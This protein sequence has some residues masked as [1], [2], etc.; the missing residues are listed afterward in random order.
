[1]ATELNL[2][3]AIAYAV[4]LHRQ[5]RLDPAEALYRR[6]LEV[7]PEH[8]DVLHFLGV[9]TN[10]KGR[11]D[12]AIALIEQAI[13][14]V[15]DFPDFHN[16]LGNILALAGRLDEAERHYRRVLELRLESPDTLSNLATLCRAQDRVGEAEALLNTALS[17]APDHLKSLNNFGL[18]CDQLERH[19]DAIGYYSRAISLMPQHADGHHLLGALYFTQ[20]RLQEA[21][22]VYRHWMEVTPDHPTPRHMYAACSGIDVPVRAADDYVERTFDLFAESFEQQLQQK[23]SYR[24]PELVAEASARVLPAPCHALDV[25]DAGCGTG[26][27]GPL[28]KPWA[29]RMV[30]VDLSSGMLQKATGKACYDELIKAELTSWIAAHPVQFDLIV[31]AD[32]LCYF[33]SLAEP[34]QAAARALR[35]GGVLTF[36][37]EATDESIADEGHKINPHGRYSHTIGHIEAC[38][39]ASGFERC[40]IDSAI[41]RTENGKPVEGLVVVARKPQNCVEHWPNF[42]RLNPQ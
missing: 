6:I 17:I 33:G 29:R 9:L 12:E 24:A 13:A 36:S 32:T 16:N 18:L 7:A 4:A 26:L 2:E 39:R 28:F 15:P 34:I 40:S 31:S 23:L 14:M 37:V 21:A 5:R 1:M 30:G 19:D 3:E 42:L 8:P 11:P 41:L 22:D 25:L 10:Q 38:L 20:G 35:A 27:C